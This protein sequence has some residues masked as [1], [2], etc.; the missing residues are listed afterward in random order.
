MFSIKKDALPDDALLLRY[1]RDGTY[2]NYHMTDVLSVVSHLVYVTGF[3]ITSTFK[4]QWLSLKW[5]VAKLPSKSRFH[6]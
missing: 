5:V 4:F 1:V 6:Y 2:M 3:Y